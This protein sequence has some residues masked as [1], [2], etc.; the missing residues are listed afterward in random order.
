[1][2]RIF[3]KIIKDKK[4]QQKH[5]CFIQN[6]INFIIDFRTTDKIEKEKII[7][8]DYPIRKIQT[9]KDLI[10]DEILDILFD[11]ADNYLKI[12][13]GLLMTTGMRVNVIDQIN[14]DK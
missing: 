10:P 12:I 2:V 14:K 5:Q 11:K 9:D 4:I 1:M 13:I 8:Y 7:T 6:T 3:K